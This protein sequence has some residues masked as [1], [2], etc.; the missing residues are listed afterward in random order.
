LLEVPLSEIHKILLIRLRRIGDIIMTTPAVTALKMAVPESQ[1]PYVV[2]EPYR[3]LVEGH[4]SVDRVIA[5]GKKSKLPEFLRLLRTLRKEPYDVVLD[6]HGGPRAWWIAL[7]A[8]S[9]LKVGYKI[10]YRGFIYDITVPRGIENGFIHSVEN[11]L[12]LVRALGVSVDPPPGLSLPPARDEEVRKIDRLFGE[13]GLEGNKVVV[14]H[15]SAGNQF[16]DWGVDNWAGLVDRLAQEPNVKIVLVGGVQDRAAEQG[17]KS[18]SSSLPISFVGSLNLL[19]LKEMI[20]RSSLFVGP[21]SGPMHIAA[22]TGTPIVALFGPTLPVHFSPWQARAYIV[23]KDLSCRPCR[24]KKCQAGDFPC[25][26]SITPE[27]V[28][29]ACRRF[30]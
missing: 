13:N 1:V 29:N 9:G 7:A 15:I 22:A 26:R 11:H 14:L 25:L 20:E 18:L 30:I 27:E 17:V 21:D 2:E 8:K 10:K 24:Q 3:C 6:F 23:A 28:L 4:P 5:L 16:R 12:N 19:E